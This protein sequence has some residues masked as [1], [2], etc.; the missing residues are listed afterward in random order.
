M[1]RRARPPDNDRPT[2]S[3]QTLMSRKVAIQEALRVVKRKDDLGTPGDNEGFSLPHIARGRALALKD[4]LTVEDLHEARRYVYRFRRQI[5]LGKLADALG[6]RQ[7]LR[8]LKEEL[9]PGRPRLPRRKRGQ[10]RKKPARRGQIGARAHDDG[11]T[12]Q[13]PT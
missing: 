12:L 8:E 4:Q 13:C 3:V 7:S 5:P 9:R 10:A 1:H 6:D 11:E 2:Q